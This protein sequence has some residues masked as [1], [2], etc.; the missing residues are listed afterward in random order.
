VLLAIIFINHGRFLGPLDPA[1]YERWN[2]TDDDSKKKAI[3][4]TNENEQDHEDYYRY[5]LDTRETVL[6]NT[7]GGMVEQCEAISKA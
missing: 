3:C 1:N 7:D 6:M 5:S 4:R 2:R